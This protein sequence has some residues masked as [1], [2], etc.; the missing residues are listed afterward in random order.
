MVFLVTAKLA[1]I[2][3]ANHLLSDRVV[4]TTSLKATTLG[5]WGIAESSSCTRLW[6][7]F[8]LKKNK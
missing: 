8:V 5:D 4:E 7:V 3:L 1:F 2:N 6:G